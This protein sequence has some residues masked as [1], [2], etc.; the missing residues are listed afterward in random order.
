[1]K[2]LI[3]EYKEVYIIMGDKIRIKL[4]WGF[5]YIPL[6]FVLTAYLLFEYILVKFKLIRFSIIW[7]QFILEINYQKKILV[8]EF[9][10]M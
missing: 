9:F 4:Q 3:S 2:T 5:I 1:M 10:L 7:N 6:T 8:H